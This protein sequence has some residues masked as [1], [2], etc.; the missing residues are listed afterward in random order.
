MPSKSTNQFFKNFR[1]IN[2]TRKIFGGDLAKWI[3]HLNHRA[4]YIILQTLLSFT[5]NWT[6]FQGKG[7]ITWLF[8]L[9]AFLEGD[10]SEEWTEEWAELFSFVITET[11]FSLSLLLLLSLGR[12]DLDLLEFLFFF[13][14]L[15]VNQPLLPLGRRLNQISQKSIGFRVGWAIYLNEEAIFS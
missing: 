11:E 3:Y 15:K 12:S 2:F 1:F 8:L 7:K 5:W 6:S 14:S 9:E 10:S 13:F 4:D